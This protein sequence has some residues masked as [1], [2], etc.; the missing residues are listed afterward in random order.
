M[1]LLKEKIIQFRNAPY[2]GYVVMGVFLLGILFQCLLFHRCIEGSVVRVFETISLFLI[3]LGIAGVIASFSLLCK[4]NYWTLFVSLLL[5]LW[6]MAELVYYRSNAIFIEEHSIT[7]IGNMNGVWN[8]IW[9]FNEPVDWLFLLPTIVLAAVVFFFRQT[10][11]HVKGFAVT[12]SVALLLSFI[13]NVDIHLPHNCGQKE[14]KHGIK[15]LNPFAS[16][17]EGTMLGFT[18]EQYIMNTSVVH[19]FIYQLKELVLLPFTTENY[20]LTDKEKQI[21]SLFVRPTA[22]IPA[23][24]TPLIILLIES[25]ESWTITPEIT[26]NLYAFIQDNDSL[27]YAPKVEP[28]TRHGVS[29]DGQMIVNTGLLPVTDGATCFRFPTNEYPAIS[30]LYANSAL[31]TVLSLSYWN[32]R[33]MS[34]A[35]GIDQ[36][37][38][39]KS[40]YDRDIFNKVEEVVKGYDFLLSLTMTMHAPFNETPEDN[41]LG[42]EGMPDEIRRYL[43]AVMYMDKQLGILLTSLMNDT[44]TRDATIVIT[45]DHNVLSKKSRKEF[46][47]FNNVHELGFGNINEYIPLVV[48]S[49]RIEQKVLITDTVYQMDIYPTLLHILDC[50]SYYWKGFGVNL[51]E[52]D[53]WKHRPIQPKEAQRLSD[54][55]IRANYFEKLV[56]EE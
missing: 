53:A 18:T 8:S 38:V 41:Y 36:N 2:A 15:V 27:L 30:K 1:S 52:K 21:A 10:N 14:C 33:F 49:P 3:K 32:Q 22:T 26:P 56:T 23:P 31:V 25:F 50:E 6:S 35:Y 55:M 42:V 28:Q 37:Y 12:I 48:Y 24:Q 16:E 39:V 29:A 45:S 51:L 9:L 46:D 34:D 11:K 5:A 19:S 13:A 4:R 54:K 43:N 47:G 7:M 40:W 44:T 20:N 17:G